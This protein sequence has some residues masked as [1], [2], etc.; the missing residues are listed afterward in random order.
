MNKENKLFCKFLKSN[1]FTIRK[2]D[3]YI[4]VSSNTK[5]GEKMIYLMD[6]SETMSLFNQFKEYANE[7]DVDDL[8]ADEFINRK[9][10]TLEKLKLTN[11]LK[12][13]KKKLLEL[14]EN[15]SETYN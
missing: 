3:N 5:L 12:E 6:L 4:E 11:D 2:Y 14:V 9:D 1:G 10:E 7:L 13:Y 8:I 15:Y